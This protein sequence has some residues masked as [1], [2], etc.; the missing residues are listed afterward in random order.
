MPNFGGVEMD[1]ET[2]DKML[3][4][5]LEESEKTSL[6]VGY[7]LLSCNGF[8]RDA[9][10]LEELQDTLVRG[11]LNWSREHAAFWG[12]KEGNA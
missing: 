4:A 6:I 3:K 10:S 5:A 1:F 7:A 11:F 2:G 9:T 8:A 12:K